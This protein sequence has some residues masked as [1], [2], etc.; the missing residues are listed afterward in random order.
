[1]KA[2]VLDL[3][4]G[5]SEQRLGNRHVRAFEHRHAEQLH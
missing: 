5:D 1:M 3:V 4:T 2:R